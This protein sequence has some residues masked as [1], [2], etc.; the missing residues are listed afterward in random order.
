[1][2]V[3][4]VMTAVF[5]LALVFLLRRPVSPS[6]EGFVLYGSQRCGWCKKQKD[7]LDG[8]LKYEYVECTDPANKERCQGIK[9]FPTLVKP[10][11]EVV[12][13]YRPYDKLM[14][15]DTKDEPVRK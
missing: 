9:G 2:W 11:G 14:S 1:M 6:P 10:S 4:S 15:V 8:K 3:W 5:L 12:V 13:G 7:E